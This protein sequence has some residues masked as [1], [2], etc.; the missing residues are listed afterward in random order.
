M[1]FRNRVLHVLLLLTIGAFF[2]SILAQKWPEYAHKGVVSSAQKIASQI[3]VDILKQG[4][5]AV[6]AAVATGFAKAVVYPAAGNIG[7]GGFMVIRMADGTTAGIDYREKAPAAAHEKM[8]LDEEGK[9]VRNLNH[10][11]YLAVGVPGTVAGFVVALK[12]FGT[13]SLAEVIQPAID[14]AEKG[15]PVTFGLHRDFSY[16]KKSF[17]RYP[18]SVKAIYKEDGSVYQPGEIW[19]QK[20]LAETL[21]RIRDK[22]HDGFYK[23]TTAKLMEKAMKANGGMI[24]AKDMGEYQAVVR[25]LV[26]FDYRG[27]TIH[28]M[29]PPSS[30]GITMAMTMNQLEKFD[31]A[32]AGH[33]SARYVH[34]VAEAMRRSFSQRAKYLGDPDFNPDMPIAKLI[35]QKN[36]DELAATINETKATRSSAESFVWANESEETTHYSVVDA[37]GNMVSNTY[38]LEYW[39]GSKIVLDGAGFIMNNEMGDFNPWPGHTD[40]TGLIGTDPNLVR[41]GKRM[42]S[43]MTPSIV[44]KDGKNMMAIGSPGGR[45]IINTVTQCILNVIDF[46]MNIFEAVNAPRFHHQWLPDYIYPEKAAFSADTEKLLIEMGHRVNHRRNTIGR[47]NGVMIDLE[48]G[49]RSGAADPRAPDGGAVGY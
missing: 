1:Q 8:Y 7:G 48:T 31:L 16:L 11:G 49:W 40:S 21:K 13:M 19:V 29:Y 44:T 37:A 28:S 14:L 25:D 43:S 4:G 34:L 24:T 3:G 20:D 17:S 18:A 15:F 38:T 41:P 42:L 33:N 46:D 47:A 32:A 9:L 23:G 5:N 12:K 6:D 36:G 10:E 22:G 35:S 2:S 27:Y 26:E 39:Y 45:T 30:G